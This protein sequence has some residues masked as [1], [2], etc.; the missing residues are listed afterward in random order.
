MNILVFDIG[1]TSTRGILYDPGFRVLHTLSVQTPLVIDQRSGFIEQSPDTFINAVIRISR[2]IR[3]K[4]SVDAVALTAFRSSPVLT[5]R[6]GEPLSNFIMWQDTRNKKICDRISPKN[7]IIQKK[8]GAL[9]NTVFTASKLT[10]YKEN[11]PEIWEKTYKAMVVP[12]FIIHFMTGSFVTD[13]T[14]GSRTHL[15][16]IRSLQWDEELCGL[17]NIETEKLCELIPP[18]T[19]AGK[20]TKE[21]SALTD[22]PSGTPVIS[23]R[24]E[25]GSSIPAKPK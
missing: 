20:V 13:H 7:H 18:G 14:Y 22:I 11:R 8:S 1:T 2:E 5:D 12:D 6:N 15:M 4:A 23:A 10:W 19:I 24:W 3:Q 9:V 17:F 16:N 21:F 25:W